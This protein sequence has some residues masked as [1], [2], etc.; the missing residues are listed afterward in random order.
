MQIKIRKKEKVK[1]IDCM[2]FEPSEVGDSG[3]C[4][5]IATIKTVDKITGVE[6]VECELA[7]YYG[8]KNIIGTIVAKLRNP[9]HNRGYYKD[10][11]NAMNWNNHCKYFK[12]KRLKITIDK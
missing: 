1:C 8:R 9:E 2:N 10:A 5:L 4:G 7:D 11:H 12:D 3:S 6:K